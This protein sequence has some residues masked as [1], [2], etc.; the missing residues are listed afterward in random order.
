MFSSGT[1]W[2]HA[3]E[4]YMQTTH[5]RAHRCGMSWVD[6]GIPQYGAILQDINHPSQ[7]R[8]HSPHGEVSTRGPSG[9]CESMVNARGRKGQDRLGGRDGRVPGSQQGGAGAQG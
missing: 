9:L 5:G 7:K 4:N 3:R 2:K 8:Q 6:S 1:F